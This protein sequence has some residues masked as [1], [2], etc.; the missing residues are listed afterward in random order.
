MV[1]DK[2]MQSK[3]E[4]L[5]QIYFYELMLFTYIYWA[6]TVVKLYCDS[7]EIYKKNTI[8]ILPSR[9]LCSLERNLK[10][11]LKNVCNLHKA[12]SEKYRSHAM[13][14]SRRGRVFQGSSE[15]NWPL[16]ARLEME[17]GI[18]ARLQSQ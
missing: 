18:W 9:N 4:I 8:N 3:G 5:S 11:L 7:L 14:V 10:I 6:T 13:A 12:G 17:G 2:H 16:K 15:A 1:L